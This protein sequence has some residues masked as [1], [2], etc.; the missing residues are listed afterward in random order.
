MADV[1]GGRRG[2]KL[3]VRWPL[4]APRGHYGPSVGGRTVQNGPPSF[5][6]EGD[7]SAIVRLGPSGMNGRAVFARELS[8]GNTFTGRGEFVL[9]QPI[10]IALQRAYVLGGKLS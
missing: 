8:L 4:P 5:N 9:V 3:V 7:Q 6:P 1:P 10:R 2:R